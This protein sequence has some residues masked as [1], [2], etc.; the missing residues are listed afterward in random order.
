[1]IG[2]GAILYT[3]ATVL[4]K[5][6]IG[7]HAVIGAHSLVLDPVP[8]GCLACGIPAKVVRAPGREPGPA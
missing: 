8:A 6:E 5:V 3:G 1:M 7:P 4:G 2:D